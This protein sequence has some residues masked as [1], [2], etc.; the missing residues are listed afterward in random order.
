[1]I[2]SGL[3][4]D[5]ITIQNEIRLLKGSGKMENPDLA[6]KMR[7]MEELR[8]NILESVRNQRSTDQ[9]T[10]DFLKSSI[11]DVERQLS[12]LPV[13]EQQLV[14]IKRNYALQENLYIFLLQKRAEA[15]ISKAA[16]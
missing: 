10:L 15:G 5:I 11:K 3:V 9:I 1:A 12:F 16:N 8:S 14:N 2:L 13:A 6:D 4:S 7:K